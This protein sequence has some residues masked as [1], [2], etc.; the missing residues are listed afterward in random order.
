MTLQHH[1]AL[2]PNPPRQDP[3]PR[4]GEGLILA[5]AALAG[6]VLVAGGLFLF[7]RS[8][9]DDATVDTAAPAEDTAPEEVPDEP[10]PTPDTDPQPE[11]QED[12]EVDQTEES[13]RSEAVPP[14]LDP[15]VEVLACPAEVEQVICDAAT[16]V[17]QAR[18]RPFQEFPSV[19][20]LADAEFDIALLDDFASFEDDLLEYERLLKGLGLIP[21]NLDMV[22]AFRDLLESGVV[23]F[24]DPDTRRLVV[25][26]GDF[27]LYGQLVLVHELVHA[28]DDQW[29]DLSRD[30]F[31]NADA[32]Y[33]YLAV[34][35]GN[36]SWVEELWR[37]ALSP[38]EQTMLSAQE[39]D[40]LSPEDIQRILA[41]PQVLL[42][43]QASAYVDGEIFVDSL[44]DSG[45]VAAVDEAFSEPPISSESVLHPDLDPAALEVVDVA[46]PPADG[47]TLDDGVLGELVVRQWLGQQ[48]A[49]GWGGD[50]YVV[51]SAG[52]QTCLRVDL[53]AD[54]P[55]DLIEME[56][57][58]SGW[59]SDD[60]EDRSVETI[61][62]AD[63]NAIR[64]TGCF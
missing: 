10:V 44:L 47:E 1:P 15:T 27:N 61:S 7:Q 57:A 62:T 35:E 3:P 14:G 22:Q 20:L 51:Y 43:L 45:G 52:G 53:A 38:Q 36:A 63:G 58:I 32:E 13:E 4:R 25:R 56:N 18:G 16:F 31:P 6:A 29:F 24:Y 48:A 21:E 9:N 55:T 23:G 59:V 64:A 50:A 28:F 11:A 42:A 54:T 19:E 39:L 41:L 5:V 34:I 26:G 46:P 49:A 2:D 40:A 37:A 12:D 8:Q 33:G 17:Q 30:D 60:I